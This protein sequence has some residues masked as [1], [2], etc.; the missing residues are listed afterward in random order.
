MTAKY[1]CFALGQNK[2][3]LL[4]FLRTTQ[5]KHPFLYCLDMKA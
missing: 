1:L 4:T 2:T 5:K 3:I